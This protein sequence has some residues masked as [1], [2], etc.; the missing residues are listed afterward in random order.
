MHGKPIEVLAE[1]Y[2]HLVAGRSRLNQSRP[3]PQD[4]A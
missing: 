1:L 2:G 4:R 3:R